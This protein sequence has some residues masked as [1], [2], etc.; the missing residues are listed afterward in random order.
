[1]K[2]RAPNSENL[3]N[4]ELAKFRDEI[5]AS[6]SEARKSIIRWTVYAAVFSQLAIALLE[7]ID[8]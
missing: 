4:D 7:K 3:A 8:L 6:F 5:K 2:A 1:M